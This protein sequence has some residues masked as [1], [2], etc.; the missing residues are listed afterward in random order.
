[1]PPI[2]FA[3]GFLAASILSLLMPVALLIT[4][5]VWYVIS[6]KRIPSDTSASSATLPSPEVLAA[7]PDSG[8][9]VTPAGPPPGEIV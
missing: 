4:L 6:T 5:A 8:D 9:D 2:L 7:H 1:M 3:D